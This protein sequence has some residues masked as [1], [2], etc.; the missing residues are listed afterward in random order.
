MVDDVEK[1]RWSIQK[2]QAAVHLSE[3]L[4]LLIHELLPKA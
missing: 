3:Q 2:H 1:N 4:K